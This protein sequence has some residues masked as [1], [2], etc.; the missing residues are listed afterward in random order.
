MPRVPRFVG[1]ML[2]A[3]W[4]GLLLPAVVPH[5]NILTLS[6]HDL[7]VLA[8]ASRSSTAH[9]CEVHPHGT[10]SHAEVAP[11]TQGEPHRAA[12]I[13]F[14]SRAGEMCEV[15][16][17]TGFADAR[18]SVLLA[19]SPQQGDQYSI[20]VLQFRELAEGG[21]A[22]RPLLPRSL[23]RFATRDHFQRNHRLLI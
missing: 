20:D 19:K 3:I 16:D 5:C 7:A 18:V 2:S 23:S 11:A 8:R 21:L 12:G 1:V 10:H 4:I 13:D 14:F 15:N 17:D 9:V 6:L 22:G